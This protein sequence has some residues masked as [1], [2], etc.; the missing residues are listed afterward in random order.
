MAMRARLKHSAEI[1]SCD[2]ELV[3]V[4]GVSQAARDVDA[5]AQNVGASNGRP[6]AM[7]GKIIGSIF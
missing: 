3:L 5:P 6:A 1:W 2:L 4:P 7:H